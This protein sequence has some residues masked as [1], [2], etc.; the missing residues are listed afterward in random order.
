VVDGGDSRAGFQPF[1]FGCRAARSKGGVPPASVLAL[2]DTVDPSTMDGD[3]QP[4]CHIVDKAE[5]LQ[6]VFGIQAVSVEHQCSVQ[7]GQSQVEK[8]EAW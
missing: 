8:G 7:Y 2:Q 6:R 3:D 5:H 4:K 1:A